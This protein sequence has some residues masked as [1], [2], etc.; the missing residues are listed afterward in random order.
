MARPILVLVTVGMLLLAGC[1]GGGTVTDPAT[2][3]TTNTTTDATA[4]DAPGTATTT[5]AA[6]PENVDFAPGTGAEGITNT[7]ALLD[8]HMRA[9]NGS[10]Y[11]VDASQD[12]GDTSAEIVVAESGDRLRIS[13]TAGGATTAGTDV[14]STADRSV[15]RR[16]TNGSVS[17][18]VAGDGTPGAGLAASIS[19]LYVLTPL[20][21]IQYGEFDYDGTV[22]RDGDR[23][24]RFVATG[25]NESAVESANASAVSSYDATVLVSERGVVREATVD[26]TEVV[27]GESRTVNTTYEATTGVEP[28]A[29]SWLE[30]VPDISVS[31]TANG[32]LLVVD[33]GGGP[34]VDDA[35]VS[36]GAFGPRG[37]IEGSFEAGETR[38]LGIDSE[39]GEVVVAAERPDTAGLDQLG[40]SVTF[41]LLTDTVQVSLLAG[42]GA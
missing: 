41:R 13:T 22:E 24:L 4:T 2:D 31:L 37:T 14:W 16:Q 10:A 32:S 7:S 39:S 3:V 30:E 27:D 26:A 25:V 33:H 29:P 34:A 38:Y 20:A 11:R 15:T 8:A 18:S 40:P 17:Y 28:T 5:A 12:T 6:P 36:V 1:S 35:A 23:L 42:D 9:L 21:G 19:D